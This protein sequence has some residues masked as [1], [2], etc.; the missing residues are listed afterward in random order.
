MCPQANLE[1]S[2][3]HELHPYDHVQ[4][5]E[6]PWT[7]YR[8]DDFLPRLLEI[9]CLANRASHEKWYPVALTVKPFLE[10]ISCHPATQNKVEDMMKTL[11][12]LME[13]SA[14]DSA[15]GSVMNAV[16][17]KLWL[18]FLTF[19][20]RPKEGSPNRQHCV[21]HTC[22][23]FFAHFGDQQENTNY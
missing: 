2:I 15:A 23:I 20:D 22:A 16:I 3:N 19:S 14:A 21:A 8:S 9:G 13:E 18:G 10:S 1:E 5:K 17:I 7:L 6:E 11:E 4:D 12:A